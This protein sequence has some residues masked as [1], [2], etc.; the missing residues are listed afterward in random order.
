MI[1][2]SMSGCIVDAYLVA[3]AN[4]AGRTGT[5]NSPT[6]KTNTEVASNSPRGII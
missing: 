3:R 5:L 4:D 2:L 1:P 6:K